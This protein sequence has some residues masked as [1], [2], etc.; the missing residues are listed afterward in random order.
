MC[1]PSSGSFEGP[2]EK[3]ISDKDGGLIRGVLLKPEIKEL[4]ELDDDETDDDVPDLVSSTKS[5]SSAEV[6][7]VKGAKSSLAP[8][9]SKLSI[10]INH[11]IIVK[12]SIREI[13]CCNNFTSFFSTFLKKTRNT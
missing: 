13:K 10:M 5:L 9:S 7:R 11:R 6:N 3:L 4:L 1:L 8:S 12:K 2:S